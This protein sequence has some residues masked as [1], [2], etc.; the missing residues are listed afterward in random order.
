MVF[1]SD[2]LYHIIYGFWFWALLLYVQ[3]LHFIAPHSVPR[4]SIHIPLSGVELSCRCQS[5][6]FVKQQFEDK[7][8]PP[9]FFYLRE[10]SFFVRDVGNREIRHSFF[11]YGEILKI[12][13]LCG[14]FYCT[15]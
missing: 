6:S 4:R 13:V 14:R 8:E 5:S 15:C 11:N 2:R 3:F 1:L 7:F 12:S 9:Q 10:V